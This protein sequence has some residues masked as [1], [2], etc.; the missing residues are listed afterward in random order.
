MRRAFTLIEMLVVISIIVMLIAMLLP[1]VKKAKFNARVTV[2]KSQMRQINNALITYS[3]ENQGAFPHGYWG[4]PTII[5]AAHDIIALIQGSRI[6]VSDLE[7]GLI[8]FDGSHDPNRSA[9]I[10]LVLMLC[11]GWKKF[12]IYDQVIMD[13]TGDDHGWGWNGNSPW[14]HPTYL[15]MGGN[16]QGGGGS[17][18]GGWWNGWIAY[19]EATWNRYDDPYSIGPVPTMSHRRRHSNVAL[20]T[21]RMWVA[22]P[23]NYMH[24]YRGDGI[25]G[26]PIGA[27]HRKGNNETLGGNVAFID[28]HVEFRY[29][30]HIEERVHVYGTDR[31]YVCY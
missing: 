23:S 16:G 25:A 26:R 30:Q 13:P 9:D 3:M 22:D 14:V 11:P 24:P 31:P 2:C 7:P 10:A 19:D 17:T 21:D 29:V 4:T 27:N 12:H 1:A 8:R 18:G 15:Y 5:G 20:L 28:G 6:N